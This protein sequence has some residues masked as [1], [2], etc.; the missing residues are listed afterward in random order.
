MPAEEAAKQAGTVI[1][2]VVNA[3]KPEPLLLASFLVVMV[4]L[5]VVVWELQAVFAAQREVNA[6]LSKCVDADILK[7]LGI[8]PK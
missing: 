8:L 5:G 2:S 4:A 7:A 1:T 3:L 6:L